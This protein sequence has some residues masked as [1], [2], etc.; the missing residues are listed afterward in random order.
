VSQAGLYARILA[1]LLLAVLPLL[2]GT[3]AAVILDPAWLAGLSEGTLVLLVVV[4]AVVWAGVL[5]L[6]YS[7][8]LL[9]DLRSIVRLAERGRYEG[10]DPSD[11]VEG[12]GGEQLR[13]AAALDE[14]NRQMSELA[15]QV[16]AARI[17]EDAR[18]VAAHVVATARTVTG[19]PTWTLAVLDNE[20]PESL[21]PGSY[22]PDLTEESPAPLQDLHRWAAVAGDPGTADI[23]RRIEG[24]WGAFVA[25]DVGVA[26]RLRAVLLA[27]WEGR[28]G[29]SPAELTVFTLLGQHAATAINHALLYAQLRQQTDELNRMASVQGDFLRGVSHD[30][31][32]PLTSISALAAELQERLKTSHRE[33]DALETIQHQADRLR[34]MVSQLLVVSRLEAGVIR[35][36][37]EIFRP[38]PLVRRT[39]DALRVSGHELSLTVDGV[40][41]L[42]VGDPDRF[43][44]VMWALL[45]N[46]VKY[47]PQATP[48]EVS[49]TGR[50][51]ESGTLV[52]E[53]TIVDRGIGMDPETISRAFDQFHRSEQARSM[54]PD[55]SGIGL[56]AARGLVRL[57]GGELNVAS[58]V[59]EGSRFTLTIPA[60]GTG[61]PAANRTDTP[62]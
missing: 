9:L 46:A 43:E 7:R 12:L 32:T 52:S 60:E 10:A 1:A 45:D 16:R 41:H 18:T 57:M 21:P 33:T 58:I 26:D 30:L 19:D 53:V 34:R 28:P 20:L 4:A 15:A 8:S 35:P 51:T 38:A 48:V 59:G 49:I 25:V 29:P 36:R 61:Q 42:A 50:S 11:A 3:V 6:P 2:L 22:G 37:T 55:G 13:L 17:T 23:A 39:W 5:A 47:S 24:P 54:V 27:P 31:Q 44:Q 14:R 62:S 40:D 56:Y